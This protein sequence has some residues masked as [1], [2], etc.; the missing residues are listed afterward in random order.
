MCRNLDCDNY[1][2]GVY[3]IRGWD[4]VGRHYFEGEEQ[5]VYNLE[6]MVYEIDQAQPEKDRLYK[7]AFP[8]TNAEFSQV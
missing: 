2:N 5:R 8:D 4:I 6:E 1:D 3:I 7:A